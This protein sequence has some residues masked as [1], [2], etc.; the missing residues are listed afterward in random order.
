MGSTEEQSGAVSTATALKDGL[1]K[2]VSAGDRAAYNSDDSSNLGDSRNRLKPL[3]IAMKSAAK[4]FT[5]LTCGSLAIAASL[6][7]AAPKAIANTSSA[8]NQNSLISQNSRAEQS[9]VS[10]A[11]DRGLRIVD[12][13]AVNETSNGAEVIMEVQQ[14]RNGSSSVGCDYSNATHDV[15]LYRIEDDNGSSYNNDRNNGNSRDGWQN[16]YSGGDSI[17]NQSDAE[18][19]A[20]QAVG[21]QLGIDNPNSS[22]VRIDDVQRNGDRD[23]VVEGR[24]NGAAFKMRL[25]GDDGSVEDFQ[26]F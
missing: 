8:F 25:R 18:S 20:R 16:Q 2:G 19:I 13:T 14:G 11:R 3:G 6:T 9:C 12:V 17:R 4:P 21:E 22:V 26:L 23:W 1:N 15:E 10:A 7:M 24:A 5:L